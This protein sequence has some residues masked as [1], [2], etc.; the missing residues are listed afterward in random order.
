MENQQPHPDINTARQPLSSTNDIDSSTF[1]DN[2]SA[3]NACIGLM[4]A[5]MAMPLNH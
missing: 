5:G 1:N 2:L 4:R 3:D